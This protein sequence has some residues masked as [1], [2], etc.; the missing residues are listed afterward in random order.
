MRIKNSPSAYGLVSIILHWLIAI[1]V[2]GMFALGYWMV[3]LGYYN[4]WYHK[5][6][7][8]HKSI[9]VVLFALLAFRVIWRFTNQPV[10]PVASHSP[11]VRTGAKIAHLLMYV[12]L[13]TIVFSG[14]LISTADG[15]GV[16]VFGLFEVPATLQGLPDQADLA[17]FIHKY[18]AWALMV[19]V[20]I[21]AVAA[22]KHH[23]FEG[24]ETLVRM[25][26]KRARKP[27]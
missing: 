4:P 21:H 22:L 7:A 9:G 27:K 26:G 6:P 3:D 19:T 1:V 13:F 14:Y 15:A 16:L 17:G 20:F 23:W 24:D 18:V 8:L 11:W 10:Q 5:A 25:F 2:L 12:M